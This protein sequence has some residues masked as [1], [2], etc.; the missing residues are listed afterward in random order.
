[1]KAANVTLFVPVITLIWRQ[2]PE[3][4]WGLQ[5]A[6]VSRQSSELWFC[7]QTKLSNG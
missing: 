2:V 5:E 6:I 3:M 1:M 4:D 7:V